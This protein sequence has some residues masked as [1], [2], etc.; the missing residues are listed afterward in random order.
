MNSR[1]E[2]VVFLVGSGPGVP[3]LLSARARELLAQADAIVYDARVAPA[4]LEEH[5]PGAERV[6][7]GNRPGDVDG[8]EMHRVLLELCARHRQ[9]VR[10]VEG[11]PFFEGCA[12][13]EA[14]RLR[15][16][17]IA[18]EVVP[19]ASAAAAAAALAGIPL[20]H[21]ELSAA[22]T[23]VDLHWGQG[24]VDPGALA[25][26]RGTLVVSLPAAELDTVVARL[27]AAGHPAQSPAAVVA[28]PA[29]PEQRTV[30]GALA[31]L[32]A[33]ARQE[34]LDG[35]LVLV[36]GP[37]VRL[38]EQLAWLEARPLYGKRVVVTR[39][40]AQAAGFVAELEAL[41][42]EV[43]AFP[44]IRIVDPADA[45]P[46][47][48]AA[49]E[50]DRFDWIV[51]TSVNAVQRFWNTLRSVGR[52][53]RSLHGV[54]LCAI[55]PATAAAIELEGAHPDLVP[56]R[57]VAEEVVAALRAETELRGARI[58]LPRAEL[59]RAVLPHSLRELGAEVVTVTA[60][61]TVP[62]ATA[63]AAL[64]ERL[65]AGEVDL[66]TF[67][68]SSTVRNF[69]EAVGPAI[70]R[71]RVA[72]IGPITSATARE[73]GLPVHVEAAEYTV[74]GLLRALL[75]DRAASA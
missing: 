64:R 7:V 27:S 62:D 69:V 35:P 4:L 40:R 70:G 57:F 46:L 18:F 19:T 44:T 39:P 72:S 24:L 52:D 42:A 38:R 11:S 17:G 5:A 8:E 36:L 49:A 45:E 43:L 51:F 16:A 48:R 9:V 34:G 47:R 54:S 71:A 10:L 59:A 61:R 30:T 73:V 26:G 23:F 6:A 3:A 31:A 32:P 56:P 15:R 53:T 37:V 67:T 58:L 41:G 21:P 60:Y 33:L 50:S 2:T 65:R 22:V 13:A 68:S 74:P 29:Q 1:P 14:V 25:R 55:G 28:R 63:V 12:G 66:I 75:V 20:M